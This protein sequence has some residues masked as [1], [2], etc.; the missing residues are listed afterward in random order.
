LSIC[1]AHHREHASNALFVTDQNRW[2][3]SH[4]VQPADTGWRS[5]PSRQP[6]SAVLRSPPSVTHIMG[7]YLFNRPRRDGS[8]SWPCWLTDSGHF[9]HKVVKQP[10]ISL[11][12]DRESSPARTDVLTTI[13]H[14]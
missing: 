10:S 2:P 1:I 14:H 4:R 3:H 11:A 13:L 12:Q 7:H 6:Q 9:N 5:G 8:L